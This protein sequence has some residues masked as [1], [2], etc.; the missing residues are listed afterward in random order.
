MQANSPTT[1]QLAGL[2]EVVLVQMR[3]LKK[4]IDL[5]V[6]SAGDLQHSSRSTLP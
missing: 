3:Y 2:F 4:D 6:I 1:F 5:G